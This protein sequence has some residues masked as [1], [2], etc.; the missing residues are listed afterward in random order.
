MAGESS[1]RGATWSDPERVSMPSDRADY[2]AVALSPEGEDLYLVYNAFTT[3]FRNTTTQARGLVGVVRH[4]EVGPAGPTGW[5]RSSAARPAT[6]APRARTTS[7]ASFWA[8]TSTRAPRA[9]TRSPSGMTSVR[10]PSAPRSTRGERRFNRAKIRR[11]H[12]RIDCPAKFGNTDIFGW[13]GADP[14]PYHPQK[15]IRG[16]PFGRPPHR[17]LSERLLSQTENAV[18]SKEDHQK[19]PKRAHSEHIGRVR[20]LISQGIILD[21][22][23]WVVTTESKQ[24]SGEADMHALVVT[25]NVSRVVKMKGSSFFRPTFYP[26]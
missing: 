12:D 10:E 24:N 19:R 2:S 11:R 6:L 23:V 7:R 14:T 26:G 21:V 16:R 1:D 9:S 15:M 20:R 25:V 4:A 5:R 17:E 13:S 3:P 22:G 18:A 8:T